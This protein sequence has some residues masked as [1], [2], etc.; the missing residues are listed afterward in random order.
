MSIALRGSR[1]EES[2][3]HRQ[4]GG[5]AKDILAQQGQAEDTRKEYVDACPHI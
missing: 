4:M 1:K 2:P 5:L 3:E